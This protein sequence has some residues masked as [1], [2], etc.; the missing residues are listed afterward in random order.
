ME[1]GEDWSIVGL[2]NLQGGSI[3][4]HVNSGNS[5]AQAK[6]R[7]AQCPG[8]LGKGRAKQGKSNNQSTQAGCALGADVIHDPAVDLHRNEASESGEHK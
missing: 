3:H 5:K 2:L 1:E 4:R 6:N 8:I 7:K